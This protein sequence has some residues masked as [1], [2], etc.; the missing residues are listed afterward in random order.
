MFFV[1]A[2]YAF[3]PIRL[4]PEIPSLYFCMTYNSLATFFNPICEKKWTLI[5][6]S[7]LCFCLEVKLS[8]L[9]KS[10]HFKKEKLPLQFL[11]Q[12]LQSSCL[13]IM[14]I[15]AVDGRWERTSGYPL[16]TRPPQTLGLV[17]ILALKT[18]RYL[19]GISL[20]FYL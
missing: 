16:Y 17:D 2:L 15:F 18:C 9:R 10:C 12:F 11:C 4:D 14:H 8:G 7:Y 3:S 19:A 20:K 1:G 6:T 13:S 5:M